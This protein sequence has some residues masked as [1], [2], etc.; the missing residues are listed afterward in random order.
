APAA[1]PSLNPP[2][3]QR[4]RHGQGQTCDRRDSA[5]AGAADG[6][7]GEA[8]EALRDGVRGRLQREPDG[9][10]RACS[11]CAGQVEL[12]AVRLDERA[13]DRQA[14]PRAT[15]V[16]R[17]VAIGAVEAMEDALEVGGRDALAAVAYLEP[18]MGPVALGGDRYRAAGRRVL[19]R[20]V[21]Q[22]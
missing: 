7:G 3:M 18:G 20:V 2:R 1:P 11:R 10:R 9:G 6:G 16:A 12:A 22:D 15:V 19:Q 8:P 14:E 5:V 4:S 17:A 13:R 21:E